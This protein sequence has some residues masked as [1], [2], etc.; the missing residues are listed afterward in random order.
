VHVIN[1]SLGVEAVNGVVPSAL[2]A[3]VKHIQSLDN[4]PAIVASAGNNG[5]E[6]RV[7][8]AALPGVVSVAALQAA[9]PGSGVSPGG[10]EWSSHGDWVTCSAVGEGVVSTFVKGE[11]DVQFGTD[12]Y[13]QDSWA[14]WSGTSFAAPQ[15]AAL[16]AKACRGGATPKAAVEDLFPTQGRPTDGYGTRV[17]LLP[18]TRP[19]T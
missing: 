5:T 11:E 1:L 6:E 3:A 8:P 4:P 10:A 18:G 15:I 16:I 19:S 17:V 13:P 2:E 9:E 14:V 12:V 7:Y